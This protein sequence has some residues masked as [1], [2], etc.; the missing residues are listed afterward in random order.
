MISLIPAKTKIRDVMNGQW[1][2]NADVTSITCCRH[3]PGV[4]AAV[5]DY[6]EENEDYQWRKGV[7]K[8]FALTNILVANV[9]SGQWR[10]NV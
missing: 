9:T 2:E 5:K 4:V 3:V 6:P 1:K 7:V 8:S 10:G